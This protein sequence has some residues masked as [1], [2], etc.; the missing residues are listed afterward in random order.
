MWGGIVQ[1]GPLV[2][3]QPTAP[4]PVSSLGPGD[5][6]GLEGPGVGVAH[7]Q[8]VLVGRGAPLEGGHLVRGRPVH[9]QHLEPPGHHVR[10]HLQA[11]QGQKRYV[12]ALIVC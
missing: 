5:L 9:R 8:Q 1:T 2:V 4:G 6:N 3:H 11:A 10:G 12:H 7:V